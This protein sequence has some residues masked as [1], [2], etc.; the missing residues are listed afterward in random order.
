MKHL[1]VLCE[2]IM[3]GEVCVFLGFTEAAERLGVSRQAVS[4]S[5]LRGPGL[6]AGWKVRMVPRVFLVRDLSGRYEVCK[7]ERGGERFESLNL[8]REIPMGSVAEY[9]DI[10]R[11]I[12][13]IQG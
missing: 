8:D 6:C 3:D 13:D 9:R 1:S 11:D 7:L 2:R 5:V 10:T 12:Y 4:R